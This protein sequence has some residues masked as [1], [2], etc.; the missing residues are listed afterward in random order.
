MIH[1]ILHTYY[2]TSG[3]RI[4]DEEEEEEEWANRFW[5]S[6]RIRETNAT[7]QVIWNWV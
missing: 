1:F 6:K 5:K 2:Y 7:E 4:V 3:V